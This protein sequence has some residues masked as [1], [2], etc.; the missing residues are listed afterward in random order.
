MDTTGRVLQ[1]F[2][3]LM[4]MPYFL[5]IYLREPNQVVQIYA[6]SAL[7]SVFLGRLGIH[8]GER[9]TMSLQEATISTV[10]AWSLVSLI[11]GM[12]FFRFLSFE[13]AIFESVAGIT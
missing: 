12:P 11:G 9:G 7:T 3:F 10:L 5:G 1:V 2:A 4:L 13:H 6:L 8:F